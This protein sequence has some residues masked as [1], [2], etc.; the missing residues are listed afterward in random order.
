M[1]RAVVMRGIT[2]REVCGWKNFVRAT[3]ID[4][5]KSSDMTKRYGGK[6][7]NWPLVRM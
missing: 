7:A 2:V 1:A 4:D 6:N 5:D 3:V